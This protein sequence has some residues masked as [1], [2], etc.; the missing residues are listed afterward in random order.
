MSKRLQ[1]LFEESEWKEI[2][3]TARA[4]RMTMA[5]WVRQALRSARRGASSTDIDKKLSAIRT[6]AGYAFPT[7]DLA[8]MNEEIARGYLG[9]P[10]T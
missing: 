10:G 8:Q 3:K 4:Q 9:S 6:A 7:A 2:Q 1:V 5:Q